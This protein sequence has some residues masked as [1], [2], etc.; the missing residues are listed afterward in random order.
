MALHSVSRSTVLGRDRFLNRS[1]RQSQQA[2]THGKVLKRVRSCHY[3]A[4]E[5]FV[6]SF[7]FYQREI[8]RNEDIYFLRTN[9]LLGKTPLSELPIRKTQQNQKQNEISQ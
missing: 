9:L 2:S 1:M 3:L 4:C 6:V 8:R 7:L 5:E